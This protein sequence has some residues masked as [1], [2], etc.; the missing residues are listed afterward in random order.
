MV[1]CQDK[2]INLIVIVKIGK[3]KAKG[4]ST[5]LLLE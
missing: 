2:G 3:I 4:G 1:Y 5:E